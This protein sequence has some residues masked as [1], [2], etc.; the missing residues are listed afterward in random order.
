MGRAGKGEPGLMRTYGYSPAGRVVGGAGYHDPHV[1][2]RL[3]TGTRG[4]Q[5]A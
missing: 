1:V 4:V 2:T 5:N 3:G